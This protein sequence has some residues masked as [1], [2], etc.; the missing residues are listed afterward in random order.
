MWLR[1][2]NRRRLRQLGQAW[3]DFKPRPGENLS[4]FRTESKDEALRV[5]EVFAVACKTRGP[6]DLAGILMP[7]ECLQGFTCRPEPYDDLPPYLR[8]RHYEIPAAELDD[9]SARDLAERVLSR[10][11][12]DYINL[13]EAQVIEAAIRLKAQGGISISDEWERAL[14]DHQKKNPRSPCSQHPHAIVA[15]SAN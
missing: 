14:R 9:R 15:A 7:P 13:E 3:R 5:A 12:H 10:R 1:F 2:G 11:E 6:E 4:I 8:E